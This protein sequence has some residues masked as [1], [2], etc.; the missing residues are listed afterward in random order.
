MTL[1][2]AIMLSGT[3]L[4]FGQT[5]NIHL[6]WTGKNK[7]DVSHTMAVTWNAI[8]SKSMICY[9]EDSLDLKLSKSPIAIEVFN[10]SS[11]SYNY[12]A[13]LTGLTPGRTYYYKC[14]TEDAK[15]TPIYSFKTAPVAG[16]EQ[17]YIIGVWGDTQ[18]NA[19][20]LAF[21]QTERIVKQMAHYP[22][23]LSIHMGD[24]VEN[25]SVEKSW[26]EFLKIAQPITAIA[27]F[28]PALG[29]HDVN[30][31]TKEKEFQKPFPIFYDSF[32]LPGDHLNYSY[33]YG[34]IHFVAVNSGFAQGAAK[35]GKT[36][37]QKESADYKWLDRDLASARKNRNITWIILYAH[38]PIYSFGVSHIP[39]WQ[40]NISPLLDQYHVDLCL[41]GH[42]HVYERHKAMRN[43]IADRQEDQMVYDHPNGTVYITNGSSGG[44]L[45]GLGGDNMPSMVY[46]AKEKVYTYAIM[47]VQG[48]K[49]IYD[50][51]NSKNAKI[52]SFSLV[53]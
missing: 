11:K 5:G 20:N 16:S 35:E 3:I 53:K 39:E 40:S 14:G 51:Y 7:P 46:T 50:V 31:K 21:E 43:G 48:N 26:Y 28:M 12:K 17:E 42:R 47:T 22:L 37:M 45:Q 24:I 27:P 34:N 30:N 44:S 36:L 2:I 33:D 18:N 29:N 10:G 23:N 38:Y 32:N 15:W 8:G 41:T 9:G 52:D 6:S 13:R 25:G 49:I 4:A 19:G 1:F